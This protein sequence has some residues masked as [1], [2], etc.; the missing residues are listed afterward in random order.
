MQKEEAKEAPQFAGIAMQLGL[1]TPVSARRKS[2]IQGMIRISQ[3]KY[4][5]FASP[6]SIVSTITFWQARAPG[7]KGIP[8]VGGKLSPPRILGVR[9]RNRKGKDETVGKIKEERPR[10]KANQRKAKPMRGIGRRLTRRRGNAS[11]GRSV[12]TCL[13]RASALIGISRKSTRSFEISGARLRLPRT[14]GRAARGVGMAE[15]EAEKT[16]VKAVE[17]KEKIQEKERS[18]EVLCRQKLNHQR[19]GC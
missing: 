16:L 17:G 14:R 11:M 18:L 4:A 12:G 3:G 15:A 6:Q 9:R 7:I 5:S 19:R 8:E 13:I 2:L 1:T 10:A